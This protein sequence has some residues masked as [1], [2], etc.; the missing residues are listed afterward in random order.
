MDSM[1]L[2]REKGITIQSAATFCDWIAPPPPSEIS[3][4]GLLGSA[5]EDSFAINIIDT[6]GH[7][8]FTIEVERALRVLDGA[9]LVLCSVSGVQ[10]Q[11]ITVDRQMRRY[12]VPRLAFIN[13]M[14]R[15]GANPFR[16]VQQLRTKLRMNAAAVQVPIGAEADFAGV[17]DLVRMKAIYN[18][19]TKGSVLLFSFC[20]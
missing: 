12:N 4:G 13:K 15:A 6:P 3:D 11:T 18:E 1:D 7:V 10:S 5:A 16:V 8:D 9:V 14:D 20:A 19:G 2:E 17:V